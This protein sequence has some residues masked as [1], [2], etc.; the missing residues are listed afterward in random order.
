M[1][2]IRSAPAKLSNFVRSQFGKRFSRFVL[3]ALVSAGTS[4]LTLLACYGIFNVTPG[5]SSVAAWF[6]GALV[7]YFMTRWTWERKG[8]PNLLKETLPFWAISV[9]TIIVLVTATKIAHEAAKD[10]HLGNLERIIFVA[11]AYFAANCLTFLTRFV[12]FHYVLFADR[13]GPRAARLASP[14]TDE[15]GSELPLAEDVAA[16]VDPA[17]FALATGPAAGRSAAS[18]PVAPE[19]AET[20]PRR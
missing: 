17:P 16:A 7:S 9:G 1:A 6:A 10:W 18:V 4:E 3:A 13:R 2:L 20:E 19:A 11:G 14:L 15:S 12:L 8:R 5:R